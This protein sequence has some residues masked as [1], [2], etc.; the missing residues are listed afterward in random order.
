[1]RK[2]QNDVNSVL[3][4]TCLVFCLSVFSCNCPAVSSIV[5]APHQHS[6][7][8]TQEF[9]LSHPK[10]HGETTM[11][12]RAQTPMLP[13]V[14][15]EWILT[16]QPIL[17]ERVPED[18]RRFRRDS[19]SLGD[20]IFDFYVKNATMPLYLEKMLEDTGDLMYNTAKEDH[21]QP[22]SDQSKH[23]DPYVTQ[24]KG[25]ISG[26]SLPY[27]DIE[28]LGTDL[29]AEKSA[30]SPHAPSDVEQELQ[31][32]YQMFEDYLKFKAR[33]TQKETSDTRNKIET[34]C[35]KIL[36]E[37]GS[38]EASWNKNQG[39][40]TKKSGGSPS[41]SHEQTMNGDSQVE[42]ST[43]PIH[44]NISKQEKEFSSFESLVKTMLNTLP[45]ASKESPTQ[46][47]ETEYIP[48]QLKPGFSM[49]ESIIIESIQHISNDVIPTAKFSQTLSN[50]NKSTGKESQKYGSH[51]LTTAPQ[52][53]YFSISAKRPQKNE[54]S[55]STKTPQADN[56]YKSSTAPQQDIFP[57][58]TTAPHNNDFMFNTFPEHNAFFMSNTVPQ[59]NNVF[60]SSIVPH[61]SEFSMPAT[62]PQKS[63]FSMSTIVPQKRNFSMS[64][65]VPQLNAFSMSTTASQQ[66]SSSNTP[67]NILQEHVSSTSVKGSQ[68]I[69]L[70]TSTEG[71]H[72][73][74]LPTP[75]KPIH[76][77]GSGTPTGISPKHS[78]PYSTKPAQKHGS[79]TPNKVSQKH[80]SPTTSKSPQKYG[81]PTPTKVSQKHG[82]PTT[83]KSPQK[84]G[85]PTTTKASQNHGSTTTTKSP[86]R[87]DLHT[88]TSQSQNHSSSTVTKP[89]QRRGS[90]PT[91][92]VSQKH[93]SHSP[94]TSHNVTMGDI[95]TALNLLQTGG[96]RP[97]KNH[98]SAMNDTEI[99]HQIHPKND[100]TTES[101]RTNHQRG[102]LRSLI[103]P[104]GDL[105][106]QRIFNPTLIREQVTSIPSHNQLPLG[107]Q[108]KVD[109][110][111]QQDHQGLSQGLPEITKNS[112][113]PSLENLMNDLDKQFSKRKPTTNDINNI[114]AAL[115]QLN[116]ML[117]KTEKNEISEETSQSTTKEQIFDD[118]PY[119]YPTRF[120]E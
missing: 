15:T 110:S 9:I 62:V 115:D 6:K 21:L 58:S 76:K 107:Q 47:K 113:I 118:F 49:K 67:T 119:F 97:L 32:F 37:K 20:I 66:D 90:P 45:N 10:K 2:P 29:D 117:S 100:S 41:Y 43:D 19:G 89:S 16:H 72:K 11:K 99:N 44:K 88:A 60:T 63:N 36:N 17:K 103:I 116:A 105:H 91:T 56:L 102:L 101:T 80:G 23:S 86:Q 54:F 65:T 79:A 104:E 38:K 112:D 93:S 28:A 51:S 1:M 111:A 40:V 14:P 39:A 33:R 109:R 5:F 68:K 108:Y 81:L 53:D 77:H 13:Y 85:S 98:S 120:S 75:N 55:K 96:L 71:S 74:V 22:T 64:A 92:K 50:L 31:L 4:F 34:T 46:E 84:H 87:Y 25:N 24:N 8:P 94:A 82:S 42:K 78:S 52:K 3:T 48:N 27:L 95:N 83:S 12:H 18:L 7:G 30:D 73:H 57:V 26:D 70:F 59:Q 114:K 106:H 61:H 69:D 35:K